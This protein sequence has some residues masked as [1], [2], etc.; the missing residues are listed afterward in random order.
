MSRQQSTEDPLALSSDLR[1]SDGST[2]FFSMGNEDLKS[3]T[4][5]LHPEKPEKDAAAVPEGNH[6]GGSSRPEGEHAAERHQ[7]VDEK[8]SHTSEERKSSSIADEQQAGAQCR[9]K[10]DEPSILHPARKTSSNAG[11]ALDTH[12]TAADDSTKEL[13]ENRTEDKAKEALNILSSSKVPGHK[14]R[15]LNL[16]GQVKNLFG[17]TSTSV[18]GAGQAIS[19]KGREV[20]RLWNFVL[21]QAIGLS[22]L[23]GLLSILFLAVAVVSCSWRKHEFKFEDR[24]GNNTI[25]VHCGL[26]TVQRMHRLKRFNETGTL[27]LL[28]KP[29]KYGDLI[30]SPFCM[31]DPRD[32]DTSWLTLTPEKESNDGDDLKGSSEEMLGRRLSAEDLGLLG[33]SAGLSEFENLV[34]H[35]ADQ[36]EAAGTNSTEAVTDDETQEPLSPE[37]EPDQDHS[38]APTNTTDVSE[39]VQKD[40]LTLLPFQVVFGRDPAAAGNMTDHLAKVRRALLGPVV[41]ELNCRYLPDLKRA[42]EAFWSLLIPAFVFCSLG[43][44]CGWLSTSWGKW[45][46]RGN[47]PPIFALKLLGSLSW[48]VS[49]ILLVAGL[50]A[51]GTLSDVAACVSSSGGTAVC[52]LG[53]SSIIA[54]V[55]LALNLLATVW[56]VLH[57]TD[58]HITDLKLATPDQSEDHKDGHLPDL[59]RGNVDERRVSRHTE[60]DIPSI[61]VGQAQETHPSSRSEEAFSEGGGQDKQKNDKFRTRKFKP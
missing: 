37:E 36:V 1:L 42:G 46:T 32:L 19:S 14:K 54:L 48:A 52:E 56:F 13:D 16:T 15:A 50:A 34:N 57:F 6:E 51:W 30:D 28:D 26:Q 44:L 53:A 7:S 43:L 4:S 55:S 3:E 5:P 31:E 23:F 59:E 61:F 24:N 39:S 17:K 41:Y 25:S 45:V 22:S 29:R 21:E 47:V 9:L 38:E 49:L 8:S 20:N 58:R 60:M 35:A 18:K 27:Y 10:L 40:A 33:P 11:Q 12:R 2:A